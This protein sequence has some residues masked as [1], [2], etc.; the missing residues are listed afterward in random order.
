V[1]AGTYHLI[2]PEEKNPYRP[3][4]AFF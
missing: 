1:L 4:I 3:R 2:P